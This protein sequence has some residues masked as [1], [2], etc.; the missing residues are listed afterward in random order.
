MKRILLVITAILLAIAA[1]GQERYELIE[2][3]PYAS[4]NETDAYKL[5]RCKLDLYYPEDIK[6]YA[7]LVW[8]HGGGL[9]GGS[10]DLP[11]GLKNG[12]YAIATVNYRLFGKG[13][14]CPDYTNDAAEAVAWVAKNI[15]KFGGD[16][17]KIFIGGHSAGGYLA[18][19][20]TLDKSYLAA[21]GYDAD[22]IVKSYPVSG[23]TLTHYTIRKERGLPFN[24]PL[25]DNMAPC[26]HV[27]KEGAPIVLFTGQRDLEMMA[28]YEENA[29]L[30]AVLKAIGHPV[31]LF[32]YQGTD[33]GSVMGPACEYIRGD[34][35]SCCSPEEGFVKVEGTKLVNP[36]GTQFFVKGTNLG[37]WLNP[38]GYMFRFPGNVNSPTFIN[39][40]LC[41]LVGPAYMKTFWDR[42]V[43]NYVT[44]KDIEFLASTGITT[45]RIPFHYRIFYGDGYLGFRDKEDGFRVLDKAVEWCGKYGIKVILDMHDCPGGQTGDNIDDS[46]GYPWLFEDAASQKEFIDL[47]IRIAEHYNDEPAILGYDFMNEP[48][49]TYFEGELREKLNGELQPLLT[50]TSKAVREVDPNHIF[51]WGGAQWNGNFSM[52]DD[53]AF[54][55]NIAFTC[56]IYG[57]P[58]KAESI[59]HFKN[60]MEKSGRYMFMGETGENSD[61]WV[62]GMREAMDSLEIGWTF[63]P[64]KKL[65]S[66]AGYVNI[67]AP[68][69]WKEV[70][71]EFLGADR[72]SYHKIREA[73]PDQDQARVILDAYL[74]NIS[75]DKCSINTGYIEAQGLTVSN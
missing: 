5:E 68:E 52:F 6:D 13:A 45:L 58:P 23:Q 3:I 53:F 7:V 72:S 29:L 37:N 25:I 43:E 57:C 22:K 67:T 39:D 33:H 56:H 74:E 36:D 32:E 15:D 46:Y 63:W 38:E 12:G 64:Y 75:F 73:R 10:K 8:F 17:S 34:I 54:D 35:K 41:Q 49:A 62:R 9:E 27:R 65:E 40:G 44:E 42:F 31:E 2:N 21:F 55:E 26:N 60:F 48:I 30:H 69:G 18:L 4:E 28:R 66:T 16:P 59:M 47:W 61:E 11:A 50:R 1:S 71:C 19:M 51:F 70:I 20:L 14:K 24:T